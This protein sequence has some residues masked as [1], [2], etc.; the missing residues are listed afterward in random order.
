[1]KGALTA[2][3]LVFVCMCST[4]IQAKTYKC[5]S[6]SGAVSYQFKQCE[7]TAKK[8]IFDD[9]Y[10]DNL[11]FHSSWFNKPAYLTSSTN[12]TETGCE[13]GDQS[14]K[15]DENI[16]T[17]VLNSLS[18][19]RSSWSAIKKSNGAITSSM[20]EYHGRSACRVVMHQKTIKQYFKEAEKLINENYQAANSALNEID[21]DCVKPE[22]TGWTNSKEAK[23][24]VDCRGNRRSAHNMSVRLKKSYSSTYFY[25]QEEIKKLKRPRN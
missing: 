7:S 9:P 25:L 3:I 12:C 13:C 20:R 5:T 8:V 23:E 17:R 15:Y 16:E 22:E 14:Y 21:G 18:T 2:L 24:W 1:M 4:H 6:V 11:G 10:K 19:L